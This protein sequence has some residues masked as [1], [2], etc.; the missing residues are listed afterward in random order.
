MTYTALPLAEDNEQV[1][2]KLKDRHPSLI[3]KMYRFKGEVRVEDFVGLSFLDQRT[4]YKHEH[5]SIKKKGGHPPFEFSVAETLADFHLYM[6]KR[7]YR[8][9]IPIYFYLRKL[10]SGVR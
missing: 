6:E 3:A 1:S 9:A 7:Q 10:A 4:Q 8:E 5:K 2:I